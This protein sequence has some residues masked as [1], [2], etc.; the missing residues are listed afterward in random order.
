[1]TKTNLLKHAGYTAKIEF[2]AEDRLFHGRLLGIR[3]VV[4]FTGTTVD[5]LELAMKNSIQ[6]YLEWHDELGQEPETPFSGKTQLRF[7]EGLHER[8]ALAAASR[9]QSLNEFIVEAIRERIDSV[10]VDGREVISALQSA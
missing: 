4:H 5:E 2:D 3:D 6:D 1:M 10:S 9:G 8:A 7:P